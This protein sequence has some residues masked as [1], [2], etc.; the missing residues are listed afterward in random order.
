M[1]LSERNLAT[2]YDEV[3]CGNSDALKFIFHWN[4]YCHG[5]D[6]IVDGALSMRD[7]EV[8][9]SAFAQANVLYS[10][11]FYQAHVARLQTV[12]ALVANAYADSVMWEDSHDKGQR[13]MSDV[14][15]FSGN[16]MLF[17]VAL[18]CGGYQHMRRVS[19]KLRNMSWQDHH[20]QHG[21]K[22]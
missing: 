16:E 2:L 5:I 15:R 21:E 1:T 22:I 18:I 7:P 3:T 14:L 12:I 20:D 19:A 4:I 6:D 9:V 17:A 10:L 11:P 13:I 8:V